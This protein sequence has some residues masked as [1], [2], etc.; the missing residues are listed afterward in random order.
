MPSPE[1]ALSAERSSMDRSPLMREA[2]LIYLDDLYRFAVR[3]TR[4]AG[5]ANEVVQ[6]CAL[7]AIEG[8][9]RLVQNPRSWLFKTLYHIFID[10]RRKR[11]LRGMYEEEFSGEDTEPESAANPLPDVM[12]VEDVRAAVES[13]PPQFRAVV[14]LS[15]AEG[16]VLREIAEILDCPLGTVA[17]RLA[18][19]REELRQRL[20][21]YGPQGRDRHDLR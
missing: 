3:L 2:V 14:W 13:L 19:G 6:E 8:R 1:L 9:N 15:D 4:D 20:S 10:H 11:A 5:Q 18:R 7:R 12:V 17:S 16:F 21:A